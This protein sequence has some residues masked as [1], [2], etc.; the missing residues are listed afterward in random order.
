MPEE[1]PEIT[2]IEQK[3]DLTYQ[4]MIQK[5]RDFGLELTMS[6]ATTFKR[7]L[8]DCRAEKKEIQDY[9]SSGFETGSEAEKRFF[10][11]VFGVDLN[12]YMSG[13]KNSIE[14]KKRMKD[15]AELIK[16]KIRPELELL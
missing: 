15:L 11:E 6:E 1:I 2:P 5:Y 16:I 3:Q 8:R 14:A 10:L 9:G 4:M 7:I 12:S 13:S